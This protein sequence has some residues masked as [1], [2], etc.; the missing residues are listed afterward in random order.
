MAQLVDLAKRGY[1]P[2]ELPPPF[3]TDSFG[4]ALQEN[5][6]L[7]LS[8]FPA[9]SAATT[10]PARHS[11]VR[12]GSLRRQLSIPN[13]IAFY[14][15]A[16]LFEDNWSLISDHCEKSKLSLTKPR[17]SADGRAITPEHSLSDLP[18]HR[19]SIRATSRF[20][21]QTDISNF[22][23]SIY[24]HGL[25]WALHGKVIAK[26]NQRDDSLL[27]NRMDKIVRLSQ[28]R[29]TVGIPVSPDTSFFLAE[30]L[31]SAVDQRFCERMREACVEV[32]GYRAIDDFEFGFVS[33]AEAETAIA[34]LQNVLSEYELQLNPDKTDIMELP[35]PTE[36]LW[37]SEIRMF[38][39]AQK[40]QIWALR[41]YF[42]RVFE[43]YV[44]N[45]RS[46]VL[47]YAIQRL[48]AVEIEKEAWSALQDFLLQCAM[49]EPSTLPSIIDHFH[50]YQ[51]RDYQLDCDKIS[52][53]LSV[54]IGRHVPL[55][56][57]SEVAW[58]LWGHL[59]FG[60]DIENEAAMM[61]RRS[62]DPFVALLTLHAQ[63]LGLLDADMDFPDWGSAL[64]ADGLVD[65]QWLLAYEASIKGW[66]KSE[67]L[68]D[69]IS[70]SPWFAFMRDN[71]V[72][73][74]DANRR[75]SH[76]AS[77]RRSV[78]SA[79]GGGGGGPYP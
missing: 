46:S 69:F 34:I 44:R 5:S 26:Q 35:V 72:S 67:D 55:G 40:N 4:L 2:K 21:L 11:L 56:H 1:F 18:D 60:L 6:K 77:E 31:L 30:I 38:N 19:A 74:Y 64:T 16:K 14:H 24:T 3:S 36:D 7:L 53:V 48:R 52:R 23:A 57:G 12:A 45:Q 79:G 25:P 42:N 10:R 27:G 28:D 59:L 73:F 62:D 75:E 51:C 8:R 68:D 78:I 13:P 33:R 32:N 50:H 70:E 49:V 66:L 54:F 37:V 61:L 65:S 76:T 39:I 47:Q 41:R 20:A 15:L 9:K 58:A 63:C 22:Y 43:F 29:Q 17:L 71:E